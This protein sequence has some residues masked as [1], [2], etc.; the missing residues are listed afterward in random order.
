LKT[1]ADT[2]RN[3]SAFWVGAI[4]F[5]LVL[6]GTL[7]PPPDNVSGWVFGGVFLLAA[8][9]MSRRNARITSASRN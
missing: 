8:Y 7:S 3:R 1:A 4:G 2:K 5:L 6:G 9:A